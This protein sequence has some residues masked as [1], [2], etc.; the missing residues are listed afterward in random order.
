MILPTLTVL[1]LSGA[2]LGA[3]VN[4]RFTLSTATGWTARGIATDLTRPRSLLFDSAGHLLVLQSGAGIRGY[5]LAA[6]GSVASSTTVRADAYLN[7]GIALSPDGKTL[8]VSSNHTVWKFDYNANTFALSNQ[9]MIITGMNNADHITRTLHIS[10]KHPNLLSVSRG[11]NDNLD[12]LSISPSEARAA[13]KVFDLSAVPA[14]GYDYARDGHFLAYGARNEI[15][16]A[17]DRAGNVWG[18]ENSADQLARTKDG[19]STDVHIDNPGE[20]LH[21]FGDVLAAAD[22]APR[23]Y[24]YPTCFAVWQPNQFPSS[25]SFKVGDWFTTNNN[26]SACASA[27]K[28]ALLFQAHSAPIDIK[29]GPSDDSN[30]YVSF[31]GSWNRQPPTGYK[32]VYVPGRVASDG[33]WSPVEA[34]TSNAGY[35]DLLW[36]PNINVCPT[37]CFRP[38]GLAWSPDGRRLYVASDASGEIV[39][40]SR[41]ETGVTST[42]TTTTTTPTST[43]S[44]P[45]PTQTKYGQ[46]GG[47]GWTGP[48]VCAAGSTCKKQNDWYS[49]CL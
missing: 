30:V 18:V 43:S 4:P 37:Q 10:E 14:G 39:M 32:V 33:A 16:L 3:F 27:I 24:G 13:V 45:Q 31:H 6:D 28:P 21:N 20:K 36:N 49:Q 19:V 22:G 7:H 15:G 9:Q 11:S 29:F 38:T 42:G 17:E 12:M 40:L 5:T 34:V 44:A 8:Y 46:C 23:W 25:D 48:T 1:S 47:I 2:V 35:L 26:D 41:S